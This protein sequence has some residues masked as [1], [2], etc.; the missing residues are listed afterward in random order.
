MRARCILCGCTVERARLGV[1]A[2]RR[3]IEWEARDSVCVPRLVARACPMYVCVSAFA[4]YG[5]VQKNTTGE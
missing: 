5:L 4:V 2:A 1:S 3:L